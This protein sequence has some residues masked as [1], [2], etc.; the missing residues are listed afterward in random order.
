MDW[1]DS[2]RLEVVTILGTGHLVKDT[3][4]AYKIIFKST[5]SKDLCNRPGGTSAKFFTLYAYSDSPNLEKDQK[6]YARISM[7]KKMNWFEKIVHITVNTVQDL[8]Y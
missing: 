4:K 3:I 5:G 1:N 2:D 7:Y 8:N 6:R